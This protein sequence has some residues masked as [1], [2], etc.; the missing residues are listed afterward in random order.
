M[1]S[2]RQLATIGYDCPDWASLLEGARPRQPNLDE[3]DPGVPTHGW[4]FFAAQAVEQRYKTVVVW[5]R[6]S[7]TEQALLRSQSGPC[8]S[9]PSLLFLPSSPPTRFA[10]QLFRVLLLR[11]LWL[12]LPL[13]SRTCRCGRP[14]D[15]LGH[16][17][18]ACS[19]AGVLGSRGFSLE[20][21]AAR[22][23]RETGAPVSTNLFVRDLDLPIANHDA[24]RLEVVADG[25]PLFGGAQLAIDTT[26]VSL[27]QADGRPRPQCARVDGAALSEARRRKQRTYPE[28]SGTQGCTRLVVLAAEVGGRWS[29]EAH[30]F[31]SQLA[32]AK[33]RA[34]PRVLAVFPFWTSARRWVHAVSRAL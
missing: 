9:C 10:P 26:L 17:R 32:K 2:R 33:A 21:A 25:F 18:A 14:L 7:P 24:R 23:C 5:P 22:V 6:L 12:A 20:S 3:V 27:V 31:V 19:R 28:L 34:V 8:R 13:A 4:Q 1:A 15:V 30:A 29:D 11:R 16:H